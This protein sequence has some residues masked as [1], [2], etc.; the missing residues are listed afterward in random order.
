MSQTLTLLLPMSWTLQTL[1]DV[2]E[3]GTY[4]EPVLVTIGQET[5]SGERVN[6]KAKSSYG[7]VWECADRQDAEAEYLS[8]EDLDRPLKDR[9]GDMRFLFFMFN[10]FELIRS[11]L[12]HVMRSAIARGDMAWLDTDYGWQIEARDFVARL[13][14][15]PDW[16]WRHPI[17]E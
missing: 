11:I 10:D 5:G 2:I 16:D 15:N 3:S 14:A 12:H 4:V 6:L 17:T 7:I 9:L 8:I 1:T 13:S